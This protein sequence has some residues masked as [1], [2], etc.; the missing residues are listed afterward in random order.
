MPKAPQTPV[1]NRL[2]AALPRREY[3][4]LLPK[5]ERV[6]LSYKESLYE[7]D[8]PIDYVYF[9]LVCVKFS[10]SDQV[11]PIEYAS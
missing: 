7:P 11:F 2:L 3:E 5:L 9:P 6:S 10:K 8:K 4:R 1:E